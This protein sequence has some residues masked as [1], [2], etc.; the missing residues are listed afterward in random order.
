MNTAPPVGV[1]IASHAVERWPALR[2]AVRSVAAQC[3]APAQ[4]VVVV[5]HNP[6]LLTMARDQLPDVDVLA[7]AGPPGASGTRN[8]GAA[9]IRAGLIAFLDDDAVAR[10]GW[11]AALGESCAM[12]GVLGAGGRVE[13]VW[14]GAAPAW[15][16]DEFG[17]VVGASYRGLP[18]SRQPVRGVW[19]ENMMVRRDVFEAV[20][21]FR[22]GFGKTGE[23]SAPEDTD[24]CVRAAR[25]APGERWMYVPQALVGHTVP[26]RRARLRFF[27]GRCYNEGLGKAELAA[28]LGRADATS[29]ER[30]YARRLPAAALREARDALAG[31]PLALGRGAASVAGTAATAAGFGHGLVTR[32]TIPRPGRAS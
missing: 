19:S 11:L 16:P 9:R 22:P 20:G 30:A 2:A 15:F 24:F 23:R 27:L 21:G 29:T 10:S 14:P 4:I 25:A 1:V 8:T 3:P 31:R 7:N 18:T 6:A 32:R 5:D 17:W 28:L 13:P 12:P 26:P